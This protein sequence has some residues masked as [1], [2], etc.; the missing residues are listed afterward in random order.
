MNQE[1]VRQ[2]KP[3]QRSFWQDFGGATLLL[4]GVVF[5]VVNVLGVRHLENWWSLFIALPG[6]LFLG[7]GGMIWSGNGR[8]TI[9]PRISTGIGIIV[10]TVALIFA[11][12]LNWEVWWPLMVIVPGTA[13]WLLGGAKIGVGGTAVLRFGRWIGGMMILLGFTFLADQ[14]NLIDLAARFG[15]FHWWGF[16]I[17]IPGLGAFFEGVRVARQ[18]TWAST[19]LLIVGVWIVSSGLM[20][21]FA[22]NWLSWEGMVGIGLIGTGLLSRGLFFL[23]PRPQSSN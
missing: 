17:L 13:V 23:K 8:F 2:S 3:K 6:V 15:N 7:M 10:L 22:P 18:S 12:N 1:T 4:A 5:L 19:S 21:L 9:L 20:E 11:L 14:H 16:F